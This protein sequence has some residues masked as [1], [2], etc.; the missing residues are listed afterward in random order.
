[1]SKMLTSLVK[2]VRHCGEKFPLRLITAQNICLTLYVRA[3]FVP[4]PKAAK[5]FNCKSYFSNLLIGYNDEPY[6]QDGDECSG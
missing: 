4:T 3:M 5:A 2:C 6:F 1:M